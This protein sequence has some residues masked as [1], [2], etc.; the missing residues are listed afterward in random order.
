MNE[1]IKLAIEMQVCAL[2]CLAFHW[3]VRKVKDKWFGKT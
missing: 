1:W 3:A 2:Y